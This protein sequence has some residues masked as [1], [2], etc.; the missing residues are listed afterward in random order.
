MHKIN[1]GTA[2]N[3]SKIFNK[4]AEKGNFVKTE[5]ENFACIT[6]EQ[7]R[8]LQAVLSKIFQ[9]ETKRNS[10]IEISAKVVF[11]MLTVEYIPPK[12]LYLNI[13]HIIKISNYLESWIDNFEKTLDLSLDESELRD[14]ISE[15]LAINES[16]LASL[17]IYDAVN[18]LYCDNKE[19]DDE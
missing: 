9:D 5:K 10:E 13:N 15:Y 4:G 17:L 1:K 8:K 14:R 7:S 3:P 6:I 11:N 19:T 12:T 2:H 18:D 16:Y